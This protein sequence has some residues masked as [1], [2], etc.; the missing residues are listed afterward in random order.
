[1]L[2]FQP[3]PTLF[4][5]GRMQVLMVAKKVRP[6]TRQAKKPESPPPTVESEDIAM[7]IRVLTAKELAEV[8]R[9]HP[10]TIYREL[11]SG[12]IP[13]FRVGSEWR[14]NVESIDKWRLAQEQEDARPTKAARKRNPKLH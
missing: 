13:A 4:V 6:G 10:T 11:H 8:L 5:L 12:N 14:F 9:V 1:V 2:K 3:L 7:T